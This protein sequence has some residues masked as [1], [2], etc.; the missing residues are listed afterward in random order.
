MKKKIVLLAILYCLVFGMSASAAKVTGWAEENGRKFYYVKGKKANGFVK[1]K[2]K[3]KT[4][5][6]RNGKLLKNRWFFHEGKKYRANKTG[7]VIKNKFLKVEGKKYCFGADGAVKKGWQNLEKGRYYFGKD[8]VM[9]TGLVEIKNKYYLFSSKGIL[10]TGEQSVGKL[11]YF[12]NENGQV[13]AVIKKGVVYEANGKKAEDTK[14]L[15]YETL[16]RAKQIAAQITNDRM[17]KKEKIRACFEWVVK[18]PYVTP[19]KFENTEG[20]PAVYAN[21]HFI[22][23]AGNCQSDAAAFAYLAKAIGCSEVYVCTDS[24]GWGLPHSWAE[25]EGLVYDPL[26][27]ESKGYEN[28]Y[29]V[30]Y[31]KYSLSVILH[32]EIK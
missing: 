16:M 27:A 19:R 10:M 8:G 17:S 4:C 23:G 12:L 5:Y 21:D 3:N 13:E 6:F 26:F 7:T 31:E 11:T 28:N 25:V 14:A 1:I 2:G 20:W 18:K 9:R 30:P 29:A 15:H 24:E 22:K 32:I